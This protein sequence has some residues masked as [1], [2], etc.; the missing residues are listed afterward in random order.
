MKF[1]ITGASGFVGAAL[2]TELLMRGHAVRA[3]VRTQFPCINTLD[4][5]A[6]GNIDQHTDWSAALQEVDIVMHLAARVH[7]MKD[8]AA[9]P[10]AAFRQV[11][12]LGTENLAR[13][14]ICS[15]VK[16]LVF[17]SSIKV[18]GEETK[19]SR[20]YTEQDA[21][22]PQDPYGISKWE[23]EQS[24][25]RIAKNSGME[26][27]IVRPPLIYGAKVKGNFLRLIE[28]LHRG[29]P[30]PLAG[31]NNARSLLYVGNLLDALITCATTPAAAGQTYLLSDG[32]PVS[33]AELVEKI[34]QALQQS[35]H[36]FYI[37]PLLLHATAAMGGF[38]AQFNRLF[39]SLQIDDTKL[40]KEL[41]WIPPYTLE[42]GL[43]I[44]MAWYRQAKGQR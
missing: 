36:S 2:C 16:R 4:Q 8:S 29:I 24:L 23:A 12:L 5:V 18:N 40:R 17:V 34:A 19:N 9:D 22:E 44:T 25:W 13:Q 21:P 14:A 27:V 31:A 32:K 6:I 10:L 15:G 1:L 30:L 35:S 33:T 39:G 28:A 11:N 38:T 7:M 26:V 43:N 20:R 37:P 42:Q 41:G 3:A